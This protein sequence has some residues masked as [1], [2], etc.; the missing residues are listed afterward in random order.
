MGTLIS[1]GE[2]LEIK[3]G[4]DLGSADVGVAQ[5][6][7]YAAQ[8]AARFQQVGRERVPEQVWVHA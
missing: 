4:V 5:Q 3:V 8:V 7:L 1:A 2:M 6:F